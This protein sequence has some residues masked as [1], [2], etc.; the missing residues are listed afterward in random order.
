LDGSAYKEYFANVAN[1]KKEKE[2][3]NINVRVVATL[4]YDF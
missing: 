4:F 1:K 2:G 3:E